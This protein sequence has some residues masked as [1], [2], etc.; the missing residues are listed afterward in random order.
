MPTFSIM[1]ISQHFDDRNIVGGMAGLAV[2][3]YLWLLY[4]ICMG[5]IGDSKRL[6]FW[7]KYWLNSKIK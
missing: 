6:D 7:G 4:K 5:G 1:T 2:S 3:T